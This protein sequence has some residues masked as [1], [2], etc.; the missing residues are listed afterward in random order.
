[1]KEKILAGQLDKHGKF[2]Y[3]KTVIAIAVSDKWDS[4][5]NKLRKK[6]YNTKKC[7]LQI[8]NLVIQIA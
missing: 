6:T 3:L 2:K 7:S 8:L 4:A 5:I 1:L